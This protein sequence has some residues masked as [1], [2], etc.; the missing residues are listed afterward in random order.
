[1]E[2]FRGAT[3]YNSPWHL[4]FK[5]VWSEH[6]AN[7]LD[8]LRACSQVHFRLNLY[9]LMIQFF[10]GFTPSSFK[11]VLDVIK[12]GAQSN[13]RGFR[14]VTTV[15]K[16]IKVRDFLVPLYLSRLLAL[17]WDLNYKRLRSS[18]SHVET[19]TPVKMLERVTGLCYWKY[20]FLPL[21]RRRIS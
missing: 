20:A 19:C 4:P 7:Q 16:S 18:V 12:L 6:E 5:F 3:S 10:M 17:L 2:D 14:L 13:D 1:M 9:P 8:P 11:F 15:I 21:L